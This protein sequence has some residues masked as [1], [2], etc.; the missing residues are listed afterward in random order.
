MRQI[1]LPERTV[2]AIATRLPSWY[3]RRGGTVLVDAAEL[4]HQLGV[5]RAWV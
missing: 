2:E 5:T 4:V 3:S 1:D